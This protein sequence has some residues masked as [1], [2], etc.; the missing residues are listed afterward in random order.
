MAVK[1]NVPYMDGDA[2][3]GRAKSLMGSRQSA[4]NETCA[5]VQMEYDRSGM[6]P[7]M[8]TGLIYGDDMRYDT[9]DKAPEATSESPG[10]PRPLFDGGPKG[11]G[12]P[13]AGMG[14]F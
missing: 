3:S 14:K 7:L 4:S 12:D 9:T 13:Y 2:G 11:G 10:S 5:L 6:D 8:G 1:G